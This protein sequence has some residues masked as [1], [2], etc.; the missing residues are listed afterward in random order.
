MIDSMMKDITETSEINKRVKRKVLTDTG[1]QWRTARVG[2]KFTNEAQY[3]ISPG[4]DVMNLQ[5]DYKIYR[6]QAEI[7]S[8]S[9]AGTKSVWP[10][11]FLSQESS[12]VSNNDRTV[13][14]RAQFTVAITVAGK[15]IGEISNRTYT[16]TTTIKVKYAGDGVIHFTARSVVHS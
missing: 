8:T 9:T 5:T 13:S 15:G 7:I 2:Q 3:F 12:I 16:I 1:E 11:N 10:I 4:L 14:S 6:R